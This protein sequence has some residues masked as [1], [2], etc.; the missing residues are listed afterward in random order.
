MRRLLYLALVLVLL[1]LIGLV[2]VRVTS[3]GA[4]VARS[5]AAHIHHG[6]TRAEVEQLLA[7]LPKDDVPW[8]E[9]WC[10]IWVFEEGRY[11]LTVYFD[12]SE[13]DLAREPVSHAYV[14]KRGEADFAD[15]VLEFLGFAKA[16]YVVTD[17]NGN[18]M[19]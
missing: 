3:S 16:Q 1:A 2:F 11:R 14:D 13:P 17:A 5:L 18:M 19:P 8:K 7:G 10:E 4:Y 9:R 12:D 15:R 6:M